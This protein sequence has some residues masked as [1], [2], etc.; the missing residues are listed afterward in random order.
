MVVRR[1]L[2][3]SCLMATLRLTPSLVRSRFGRRLFALFVL[4]SLLPAVALG[5]LSFGTVTRQLRRASLERLQHATK[6]VGTAIAE[7]LQFLAQDLRRVAPRTTPC[8]AGEAS[9]ACD[10]SLDYGVSALAWISPAGSSVAITGVLSPPILSAEDRARV[11]SGVNVALDAFVENRPVTYLVRALGGGILVAR[12]DPTFLW[13]PPDQGPL[14]PSM[15]FHVTN[16]QA[17]VISERS[18]TRTAPVHTGASGSF[19]WDINGVTHF[20][21]F[22]PLPGT[23]EVAAPPWTIVISEE[24]AAVL[25]PMDDFRRSFPIALVLAFGAAVFLSLSQLRRNLAPLDALYAGTTRVA[26]GQFDQPVV[27]TSRDEFAE[28]AASFNAMSERIRRQ[29]AA[30]ATA[31]EIDRTVLSSVDTRWIVRTVL[32]RMRDICPCDEVGVTLLDPTGGDEVTTWVSD[33]EALS[34]MTA[35]SGQ[36]SWTDRGRLAEGPDALEIDAAAAPPWLAAL[37]LRG[38]RS[39]VTLPLRYQSR[40]LGAI[41]LGSHAGQPWTPEDLSQA[42]HVAGQIALALTNARMVEQ[43]RLLAFHDTL[44]G[45]PN[46]VSFRRRLD[47]EL[48]RSRRDGSQVAVCLLD[49]DHFNRFNEALGHRFGDRLV[50]EVAQRLKICARSAVPA[51]EVARLG[52]DEFTVLVPGVTGPDMASDLAAAILE[53]FAAPM[54]LDGNELVVSASVGIAIHPAD[55]IDSENLLKHADVAM[56]QAKLKGRNRYEQYA[57]SMSASGARRLTLESHLRKALETGQFT[58]N[59][60]PIAELA[61][62]RVTSAEALIRWNHPEW[63]LVPPAEFI[64]VCEESGLIG[65]VGD[66]TLHTVCEQQKAWEREGLRLVPVA[67]NLSGQQLHGDAIVASVGRVLTDTGLDPRLLIIELTESVLMQSEGGAA[68]VLQSLAAL[69]IGLAID[70][71]GT[72]YSSLSYLKHFPVHTLKIDRSFIRDVTADADNA[73]ITTAIIAM[74]GA[75]DLKVVAEGVETEEQV[76]FLRRAG[77]DRVQGYFLG[78]PVA[79]DVFVE[80]LRGDGLIAT[81]RPGRRRPAA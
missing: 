8:T 47:E 81:L 61:T 11:D 45:L 50:Q 63:G 57:D 38:S 32:E 62:G 33:P 67:I 23:R 18:G 2:A 72:G 1:L 53:S 22:T 42:E 48:D 64:P 24:R 19:D 16:A 65:A 34:R 52:G 60:Q 12:V 36:L 40:L 7:R 46:R 9:A 44:T 59:Y 49:L 80:S 5:V 31:A 76:E 29:F 69:G 41:T 37:T 13:G 71:F 14:V 66:W 43:I 26:E 74:G 39:L 17:R 6:L 21:A 68:A 58:M 75:L 56:Y 54:H 30:L 35:S 20:A 10:G 55:G 79:A 4:C 70:D 77:C 3:L 28:V 25:A 78:H 15:L 73:A 51:A 27:V